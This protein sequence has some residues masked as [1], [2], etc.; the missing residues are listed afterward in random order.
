MISTFKDLENKINP[1]TFIECFFRGEWNSNSG[2]MLVALKC[3]TLD[4]TR[5][6]SKEVEVLNLLINQDFI[7]FEINN[8]YNFE[9]NNSISTIIVTSHLY[10][11]Y[12]IFNIE[13]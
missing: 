8:K 5:L 1:T 9:Q 12:S 13:R 3:M 2:L 4:T 10:Y 6:A 7:L 11:C